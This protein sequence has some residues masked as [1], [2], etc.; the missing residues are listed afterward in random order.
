MRRKAFDDFDGFAKDYRQIHNESLKFSGADSDF[1]SEQKV[2][3]VRRREKADDLKILDLG[4][5]DGNSATFFTQHFNNCSYPGL[6]T[7]QESIALA[8]AREL[9]G[10]S[11]Q[12][13]DGEHL[14]FE[15]TA[16]DVVFV[17]CVF[18]HIAPDRHSDLLAEIK[19]V[20]RPGGRL[21]IFEHNPINPL[22]RRI[23]KNCPF[24]E[25]A[26]LLGSGYS[27]RLIRNAGFTGVDVKFTIFFPG[28]GIFDRL[29]KLEPF[30]EWL[31]LGGQYHAIARKPDEY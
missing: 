26:I 8:E 12:T 1:F 11:F 24:D 6:D 4:C 27:K 16:F 18:H 14:P 21:Y 7:S 10:C 29:R 15:S 3:V 5:G 23:V 17:A 28:H 19:R 30:L 13:Y 9:A 22:T 2:E 20:L 25:D 31:P